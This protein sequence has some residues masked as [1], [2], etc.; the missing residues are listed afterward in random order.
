MHMVGNLITLAIVAAALAGMWKAFEKMGRK[1]WEGIVPIYNLYILLQ[2][3]GRPVIWLVLCI[4]PLV[5]IFAIIVLC[6]DVAKGFGKTTGYGVL[7][8]LFGFV[9]WPILGFGK[10][11]W[12]GVKQLTEVPFLPPMFTAPA[13]QTA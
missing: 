4:I 12:Q 1:G 11:Q 13:T 10:D 6:I 3:L 5:N 8:G 2:V 7:L 9:M